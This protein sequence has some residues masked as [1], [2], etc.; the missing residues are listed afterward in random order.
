MVVVV[1]VAM[2]VEVMVVGTVVVV[3]DMVVVVAVAEDHATTVVS[4]GTFH[5]NAQVNF[6]FCFSPSLVSSPTFFLG[7]G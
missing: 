1:V 6:L 3:V 4:P 5:E 2:A 7:E